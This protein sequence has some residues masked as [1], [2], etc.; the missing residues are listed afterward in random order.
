MMGFLF[1]LFQE[2][3]NTGGIPDLG[4]RLS[5]WFIGMFLLA[6][7]GAILFVKMQEFRKKPGESGK[8]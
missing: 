7:G 5:V 6:V 1:Y 3:G 4:I 2:N 8:N